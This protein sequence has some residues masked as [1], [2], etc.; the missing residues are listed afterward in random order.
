MKYG[1][2]IIIQINAIVL[3]KQVQI[4]VGYYL[5]SPI[6]NNYS[7]Y[8][9][10]HCVEWFVYEMLTLKKLNNHFQTNLELQIILQEEVKFQETKVR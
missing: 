3:F 6:G 4:A 2:K 8:F 9:G 7:S 5:I 1:R 10:T